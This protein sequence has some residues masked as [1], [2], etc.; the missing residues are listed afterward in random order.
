MASRDIRGLPVPIVV[1]RVGTAG[2][3]GLANEPGAAANSFASVTSGLAG[4]AWQGPASA[5]MA[6]A[7]PPYAG[8]LRLRSNLLR[9][10]SFRRVSH[11]LT[12][13]VVLQPYEWAVTALS[14]RV[15]RENS[16][17]AATSAHPAPPA[18]TRR[19]QRTLGADV[20]ALRRAKITPL[21]LGATSGGR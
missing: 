5:A 4:Q 16:R 10:Q 2:G 11:F 6:A 17:H 15:G 19:H 7:A 1:G 14:V 8:W 12:E 21:P 9:W 3:N 13:S 20:V 18:H